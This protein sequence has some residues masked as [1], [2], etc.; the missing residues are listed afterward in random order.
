MMS[1]NGTAGLEIR[2]LQEFTY[3]W[4]PRSVLI[5]H[6]DGLNTRWTLEQYPGLIIRHPA[7]IA[8]TLYRDFRRGRDDVTVVAVSESGA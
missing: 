8:G 3:G 7:I 4:D 5:L 6:S 2:N 1:H